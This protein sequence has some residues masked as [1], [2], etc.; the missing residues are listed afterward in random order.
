[1]KGMNT[2]WNQ[3]KLK[4][5]MT[6]LRVE[7]RGARKGRRTLGETRGRNE[8]GTWMDRYV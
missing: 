4:E 5:K 6:L 7:Q 8:G 2:I 1:M 3:I